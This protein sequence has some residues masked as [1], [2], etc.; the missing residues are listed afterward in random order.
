MNVFETHKNIIEEYSSYINSFISI[1][2]PKIETIVNG[3]LNSGKLWPE[4]LIQFN[5][6][7]EN[8]I[9]V[10]MLIQKSVL[11]PYME[12]IF[13]SDTGRTWELYQHQ[14][15]AIEI[16][17]KGQG[18]IVTSGTGSGKSLT[19]MATI[20]NDILQNKI[21]EGIRAIIVYP[22]NAL[23]NS[24]YKEIEKYREN[25]EKSGQSF[26]IRF[27]QYTGQE[28][29]EEREEL[30]NNPPHI[31]LTN[32]MMLELIMT[33]SGES[34]FREAIK[35]K[36][37]FIVFDELHTYRGRQGSDVAFLIRRIK[38]L[39]IN[40]LIPI[41]T[42]AT[43]VSNKD[44]SLIHQ[45]QKVA[46][47]ATI[48]FGKEFNSTQVVIEK[49]RRSLSNRE[50]SEE[51][52]RKVLLEAI[53]V[54]GDA[55]L[56]KDNPLAIWLEKQIALEEKEGVLVRKKPQTLTHIAEELAMYVHL[57]KQICK[58][59]LLQILTWANTLNANFQKN[60]NY[61]PYRI[62]QFVAQTGAVYVTLESVNT[63]E[64]SLDTARYSVQDNSKKLYPVAFSR[65]SGHEFICVTLEAGNVE[66]RTF[67]DTADDESG[68]LDG[69]IFLDYPEEEIVWDYDRDKDS[70]PKAWFRETKKEGLKPIKEYRDRLPKKIYFDA[71]GRYSF[72]E[73]LSFEGWFI[74]FPL[75]FDPTS[76]TFF[77]TRSSEQTKLIGLGGEGRS[78]A[79]TVLSLAVLNQLKSTGLT[80]KE[81]K[82]LSF[83]DNRQ[84]ASLQA[85]HFNDFIRVGQLRSSIFHALTKHQSL[86]YSTIAFE[87]FSSLNIPQE[88]FAQYPSTFPGPAKDNADAFR[89][90]LMYRI[91]HDLRRSWRVIMPN[92]EQCALLKVNYKQLKETM[93]SDELCQQVPLLFKMPVSTRITFF[94]Q[95]LDFF[96]KQYALE[97][98]LL[99]ENVIDR[100]TRI[101]AEKLKAPW[102]L[103]KNEKIESPSFIRVENLAPN[104]NKYTHSIGRRSGFAKWL[105]P[106]AKSF[107]EDLHEEII[108][109]ETV[110][111]LLDFMHQ[112]GWLK[113]TKVKSED[114]QEIL[115]YQ[116][117]VDMI[118]W[119]LGDLQTV[120]L[121]EI[122]SRSYKSRSL[123]P[124]LY[125][126]QFYA[127]RLAETTIEG[128]EHTGQISSE[129]RKEREQLFRDGKI[130]LLFCSPT[131]ELGIDISELSVVHMRNVPPTPANYAQ[132]SGRAGRSGQAAMVFAYCSNHSP[133]DRHYFDHA[134]DMVAGSVQAPRIDLINEELWETHLHACYIMV[135]SSRAF[136]RSIRDFLEIDAIQ[137]G[138]PLKDEIKIAFALSEGEKKQIITTFFGLIEDPIIQQGMNDRNYEW[139]QKEWVK[140]KV[141]SFTNDLDKCLNRWRTL[142]KS[143]QE[144]IV[145][146]NAIIENPIY[147]RDSRERKSA[148]TDIRQ[149]KQ[150]RDL[151]L[152]ENQG[153]VRQLSEFYPY[154]YFAS[155]GFLP[156]YNFTR[157]PIRSFMEN[158]DK[159]GEYVSR[160]RFLALREFGPQNIIYHDGSKYRINQII[161]PD[162]ENKLKTA[163]VSRL[164]GYFMMDSQLSW[165]TDPIVKKPV[166]NDAERKNV[167]PMIE[168]A[169]TRAREI[170]RIN[171]EEEERTSRGFDI[172]TYFYVEDGFEKTVEAHIKYNDTVLLRIHSMPT[173][174]IVHVN[175]RWRIKLEEGF[176]LE[177]KSGYWRGDDEETNP[178][179]NDEYKD[180][181]IF[182]SDTANAIYIQPVQALALNKKGVISLQYA[183]KRAIENVFQ[184]ESNEIGVM[185]MGE[186]EQPNILLYESAQGSLGVLS[187]LVERVEMFQEIV[188]EAFNICFMKEG[189]LIE[190]QN[191]PAATYD[192]LLSYYNQR[193]HKEIDR[194]EIKDALERLMNCT[195]ELQTSRTYDNYD[196]QYNALEAARD[197]NS[198]TEQVFLKFLYTN[199]LRLP[200]VAQPSI[201]NM[202]VRPDFLYKPN[203]CIFCDGS[204]H[205]SPQVNE[206][207]T[208]KRAALKK[209]GYQVLVWYYSEPLPQFVAKR[210][211]IFKKIR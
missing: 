113:P 32:Y 117:R 122:K 166:G 110:Y 28:K 129:T 115:V 66:P 30:K 176:R 143:A 172:K 125:F 55:Q 39:A 135:K 36:L 108:Y 97:Y 65:N 130:S 206:D 77:D 200:D 173:A 73:P 120:I 161:I 168:M 67:W 1:K 123:K 88:Q 194:W 116:I 2:D 17:A 151:L 63:R 78:T 5:P 128:K 185:L 85:G 23:I 195:I 111:L 127:R 186:T 48:I 70:L 102:T 3:E 141:E 101:F 53:P 179:N 169:E 140:T 187:R 211:D 43:M 182:T 189:I 61:L 197:P 9:T 40:D 38:A 14:I 136:E 155:E 188:K 21:T 160:P 49:L 174:R 109:K 121:D 203:I 152:N 124:N 184:V 100:N 33:R 171:C 126:Q 13:S 202:Y 47:V 72:V 199:N 142:Y 44:T 8:G 71:D 181:K 12:R 201:S 45:K 164:T 204:V 24:Q 83:T 144:Q 4:P 34:S 163:K 56:F 84:D 87:V 29:E 198:S 177:L 149:G 79:T 210:P 80:I 41:G 95:I 25:Y 153:G 58:N 103:D 16:G 175:Y 93:V 146:G 6:S 62:H 196:A 131:M 137:A 51:D 26:P 94:H 15:D 119:E 159:G 139:F 156:G 157:L 64:I 20:F 134:A 98:S 162:A 60:Q 191:S 7:F 76:G 31:L 81:S 207:D 165:D 90:Y 138:V 209:A 147:G 158:S 52:V 46:E 27:G 178:T 190:A 192:D 35:E 75:L 154:R 106:L 82:L 183:L 89:D 133:H 107:G 57:D 74:S 19:Y 118:S 69:Y 96:R 193:D 114:H 18:F 99:Q 50:C 148:E 10:E 105:I 180:V 145:R 208:Q 91:L 104:N 54:E 132:R 150:Q 59:A 68:K 37:K 205:D 92:L 112:A 11:H 170:Q 86:D 167:Y 42:S 22:M